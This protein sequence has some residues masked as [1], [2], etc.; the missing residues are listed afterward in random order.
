M[1]SLRTWLNNPNVH[2]ILA[3]LCQIA[4]FIPV[5][6]PFAPILQTVAVT[7]TG[8]GLVLPESGSLHGAD[9]GK[10]AEAIGSGVA[11]AIAAAPSRQ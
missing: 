1:N 9:Y 11:K 10:L 2:L 7:L 6:A 8:T 5:T 3:G 4:A